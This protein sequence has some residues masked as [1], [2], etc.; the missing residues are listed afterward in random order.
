[1][2]V[3]DV[4]LSFANDFFQFLEETSSLDVTLIVGSWI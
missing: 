1:M 4:Y 2:G 3:A